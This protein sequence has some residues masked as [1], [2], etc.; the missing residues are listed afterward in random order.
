MKQLFF[1]V[2]LFGGIFSTSAQN[3][4]SNKSANGYTDVVVFD[5]KGKVKSCEWIENDNLCRDESF[6]LTEKETKVNFDSKGGIISSHKIG[7]D[8]RGRITSITRTIPEGEPFAGGTETITYKFLNNTK[9]K[10][11]SRTL[12]RAVYTYDKNNRITVAQ[13]Y[14]YDLLFGGEDELHPKKYTYTKIDSH[15]NWTERK[16]SFIFGDTEKTSMERR[17]IDYYE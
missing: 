16:V 6:Q 5:L 1:I 7:R 15:G 3:N 17:I 9:V 4:R 13:G 14:S 12:S 8:G 10:E 2:M 11:I